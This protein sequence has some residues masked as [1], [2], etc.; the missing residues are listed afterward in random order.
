MFNFN[1]FQ[2]FLFAFF[3]FFMTGM[4]AGVAA[5]NMDSEGMTTKTM[6]F[7]FSVLLA[8][9]LT[10]IYTITVFKTVVI[11]D[12]IEYIKKEENIGCEG[13]FIIKE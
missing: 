8:L 3:A 7:G 10:I 6:I 12:V 1:P 5:F 9:I 11:E 13:G 4:L 2:K